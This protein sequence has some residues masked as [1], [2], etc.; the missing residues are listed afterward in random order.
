MVKVIFFDN[1]QWSF[2]YLVA[3]D[4]SGCEDDAEHNERHCIQRRPR[5]NVVKLFTA[6]IYYCL[7]KAV[8]SVPDSRQVKCLW[9]RPGAHPRVERPKGILLDRLRVS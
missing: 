9:V 2:F 1:A 5:A 3:Y 6:V 7:F 8:V 4:L